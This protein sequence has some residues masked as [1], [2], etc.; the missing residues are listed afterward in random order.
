MVTLSD[1]QNHS[2]YDNQ[3]MFGSQ[4][5]IEDLDALNKAIDA[6]SKTGRETTDN[7]TLGGASLKVESLEK[8][9]KVLTH[10]EQDL[11]IWSK[12][13]KS[14]AYNTVEEYNQLVSY[15]QDRGGFNNEGETPAEEDSQYTRRAQL[16]KFLGVT[17]SVTHPMTLV[18][19]NVANILDR[20]IKNGTLWILRKLNRG[21][22]TANSEM[23]A[24]EFNGLLT[25]HQYND[26]YSTVQDYL[27]SSYVIDLAGKK[28]S[29]AA[30]EDAANTIIEN[31]GRGT[32]L[33]APPV[34]L[35]NFVKNFY[36]NKYIVPNTPSLT[37]GVMGQKV[38]SFESQFGNIG[39]NY[40]IFFNRLP[41]KTIA[42]V[43]TSSSAPSAPTAGSYTVQT[44]DASSKYVTADAGNYLYAV[45][46]I[47]R[48]GESQLTCVN[49][50][51][52][53]LVNGAS[54][55]LTFTD[56]ASTYAATGYVIYRSAKGV[57]SGTPTGVNFYP[58]FTVTKAQFTAGYDG[59]AAGKVRDRGMY[60]PLTDKAFLIQWDT[61][62][63]EFKQLAPLMKM[64]LAV[65][66][67]AYRFMMLLYGTPFL[68]AVKKMVLLINIGNA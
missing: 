65:V 47:N 5:S 56:T 2:A 34:V 32:D 29:E 19:V 48:F 44:G 39:L 22:Y 63:V 33:F 16:V 9:L 6:G 43:A 23:V 53:A 45:S 36:G 3:A 26:Q 4:T 31:F 64:D 13:P 54:I 66:S 42:S 17:K 24:Q 18:N 68:Y 57:S 55:D 62:V 38:K 49:T 30:I 21:I 51:V 27:T 50:T 52:A 12:I 14:A 10:S 46:A 8:T 41:V 25:Q 28:L 67:P 15:G 7:L 59:G 61:D 1:Y 11:A 20:E 60:Q 35:S 40:D 37:D 58:L